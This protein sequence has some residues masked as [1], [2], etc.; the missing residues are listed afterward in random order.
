MLDVLNHK[1]LSP[2]TLLINKAPR[3]LYAGQI[4]DNP[5]W[6][7]SSHKHD[8]LS[9]IVH[10]CAGKGTFMVD[11]TTYK[12]S[13]GD[14][15]IYNKGV[16]HEE[17]SNPAHPLKTYFCG[18]TNLSISGLDDLHIIP[19]GIEPVIRRNKYSDKLKTL[20]AEI[21]DE[22]ALKA[23]GYE[24]VSK[25]LL[26]SLITLIYRILHLHHSDVSAESRESLAHQIQEYIDKHYTKS[27]SLDDLAEVFFISPYY[28]SHVFKE[29]TDL[30]PIHYL[31]TRRMGEAKR[32]LVSTNLKVREVAQLVGYENPNYFTVL[33]KRFTGESPKQFKIKHSEKLHYPNTKKGPFP[34]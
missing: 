34:K 26:I 8:D 30:S 20:L 29:E 10:I 22:A 19:S 16:L 13:H 31:I 6:K 23:D 11:G 25:H 17:W 33:F 1:S 2:D 4:S 18:V 24:S 32:L 28:L 5:H 7:F 27:L 14:T 15:L 12:V 3:L 21:F 9:E